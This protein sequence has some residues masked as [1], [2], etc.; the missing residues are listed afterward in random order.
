MMRKSLGFISK[1]DHWQ[2]IKLKWVTLLVHQIC[3]KVHQVFDC[4][5]VHQT[6]TNLDSDLSFAPKCKDNNYTHAHGDLPKMVRET[7]IATD[8]K[9]GVKNSGAGETMWSAADGVAPDL[10]QMSA[11]SHPLLLRGT[12]GQR[13]CVENFIGK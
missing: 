1:C 6:V 2:G 5:E 12:K 9:S 10:H 3:T 4:A 7:P 8:N 13:K 11:G